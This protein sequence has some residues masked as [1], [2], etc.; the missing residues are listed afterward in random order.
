MPLLENALSAPSLS[1]RRAACMALVAIGTNEALEAVGQTL[2]NG[3]EDIR[4]AA[5]E[6]LANDP[7][8]G[9]AMLRD[10]VTIKDIL[11]R[12]AVMYG[13]GRINEPWAL[14]ILQNIQGDDDQWA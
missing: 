9:H 1:V 14:E 4:R 6:A 11:L 2:L 10:G 8:E 5:G 12:R 3:D 7:V 13:L